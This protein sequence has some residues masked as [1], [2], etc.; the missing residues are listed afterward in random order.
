M[1]V[2]TPNI[3]QPTDDPSDSQDQLLQN[4]QTLNTIYGTSGD[5][6]PWTNTTAGIIHRHA[7]VSLPGLPRASNPPG[8]VIPTPIAGEGII[9]SQTRAGLSNQTTPFL[10]RDT[11]APVAPLTNIWPLMPIK[12]YFN[13]T[14]VT[15]SAPGPTAQ[16]I[17]DSFN[18]TSV[19][20]TASNTFS[21]DITNTMRTTT[22]GI[23]LFSRT[24]AFLSPVFNIVS[25]TNFTFT[26]SAGSGIS[27][28]VVSCLIIET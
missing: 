27:G 22:Y 17:N 15:F 9:F 24:G 10:V 19:N 25:G 23:F 6:F 8:D 11:L 3:P 28:N 13:I 2:Y 1:S 16:T 21:V 5:H 14:T 7:K 12:A 26:M 18:I 4:F 20:Q